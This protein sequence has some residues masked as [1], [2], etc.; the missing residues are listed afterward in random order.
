MA[1]QFYFS[2]AVANIKASYYAATQ[3]PRLYEE[4][5]QWYFKAN[6]ELRKI[7][8]RNH[9]NI[10]VAA[11]VTAALSPN[12]KWLR[13]FIDTQNLLRVVEWGGEENE[14]RCGT[15]N[16]NKEKAFKIARGENYRSILRGNKVRSFFTNIRFPDDS[17]TVTVDG[18]AVAV[19]VGVRIPVSKSPQLSDKQ[20]EAVASAYTE[21]TK[22][23]NADRLM[24]QELLPSQVQAVCWV[25]Y[26]FLH[27]LG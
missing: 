1:L 5:T 4:G 13:N 2:T 7:A 17:Y 12:N 27:N 24:G 14:V 23:I 8:K 25:Y 16:K 6:T 19:A 10:D 11:S 3:Y 26:R 20:Y 21:A 22:Q 9:V 15:Y 18:H